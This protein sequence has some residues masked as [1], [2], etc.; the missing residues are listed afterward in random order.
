MI[1]LIQHK[2]MTRGRALALVGSA[3]L[4]TAPFY[5]GVSQPSAKGRPNILVCIADDTRE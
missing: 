1:A 5:C 4:V 3:G 2:G